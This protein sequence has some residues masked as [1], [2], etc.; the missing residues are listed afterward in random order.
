MIVMLFVHSPAQSSEKRYSDKFGD[1]YQPRSCDGSNVFREEPNMAKRKE[2][3]QSKPINHLTAVFFMHELRAARLRAL[4]D[5]EE[6][7]KIIH[8]I[9]RLGCY[10]TGKQEGLGKYGDSLNCLAGNSPLAEVVPYRFRSI[11][12]PFSELYESVRVGRNDALHQGTF[13]R[14]LTNH[15]IE[16][17]IILEDALSHF[18]EPKVSSYMTRNPTCTE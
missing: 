6:F 16:L 8:V 13:A 17:A 18:M 12:T 2:Q 4:D 11:L 9:E 7:D 10:I 1:K 15:A 14:H 5:A 3:D